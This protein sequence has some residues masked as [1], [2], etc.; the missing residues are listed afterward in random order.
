MT[1][2]SAKIAAKAVEKSIRGQEFTVSDLVRGE[3]DAPSRQ[4]IYRILDQ[5]REDEWLVCEGDT[6]KP[7]VKAQMLGNGD[8]DDGTSGR[9]IDLDW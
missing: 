2:R 1:H 4:T 7:S 9:S 6:W 5:L 3:S 8:D